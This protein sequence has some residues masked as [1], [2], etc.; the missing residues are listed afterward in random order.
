[1]LSGD[2]LK[3]LKITAPKPTPQPYWSREEVEQILIVS[4]EPQCS[5]YTVLADTG[6]RIGEIKWLSWQ[7]VDFKRNVLHIRPKDDW[8]QKT[9]DQRAIPMTDRVQKLLCSRRRKHLWVFTAAPSKKYPASDHQI[10]ERRLLR[11][12]K[13]L[14]KWLDLPG[15]LHTYRHAFISHLISTGVPEAVI[16]SIVGHVDER[17]LRLYIHIADQRSQEAVRQIDG[18]RDGPVSDNEVDHAGDKPEDPPR[19]GE[20]ENTDEDGTDSAV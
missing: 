14:L 3:G 8:T 20:E 11:S 18:K 9:G 2:P 17:I 10:S 1:M 6:A 16:R 7:D 15:H 5:I 19:S 13:R 4:Q 12:L